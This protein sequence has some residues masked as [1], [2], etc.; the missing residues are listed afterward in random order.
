MLR[1]HFT[2]DRVLCLGSFLSKYAAVSRVTKLPWTS[3]SLSRDAQHKPCYVPAHAD[4]QR[5]QFNVSHQAGLV[6]L[7]GVPGDGRQ[8]GIDVTCVHERNERREIDDGGGFD[9]WVAGYAEV[10]SD[11]EVE[12]MSYN[13]PS[14]ALA[15]GRRIL[16]SEE[17]GGAARACRRH[18]SLSVKLRDG[19]QTSISSDD[20]IDAKL[21]RFYT[22]WALKEAYVKLTGEALLADWLRLLE[23]RNVRAPR[24][25]G[26]GGGGVVVEGNN[27]NNGSSSSSSSD[28]PWGESIRDIQ[29]WFN[30]RLVTHVLL[31]VQAFEDEYIVATAVERLADDARAGENKVDDL[32]PPYEMLDLERE[33]CCQLAVRLTLDPSHS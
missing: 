24:R 8:V 32:F 22:F 14:L 16:S 18:E 9:K 3:I 17:L 29:A 30:G 15:D 31:E 7:V 21:R 4:G 25:R 6:A 10:F 23:F 11:A 12:D 20:I 1:Y 19:K 2:K 5:V 27:N 26:G 28:G 33:T 13:L